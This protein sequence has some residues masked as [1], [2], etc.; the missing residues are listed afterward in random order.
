MRTKSAAEATTVAANATKY[1]RCSVVALRSSF[2]VSASSFAMSGGMIDGIVV[3]NGCWNSFLL[4]MEGF[5]H[6]KRPVEVQ[7]SSGD[8]IGVES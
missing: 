3:G 5:G 6:G 8:S 7:T 1:C 2:R 4:Q